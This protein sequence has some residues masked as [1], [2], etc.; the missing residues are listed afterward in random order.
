MNNSIM[1]I[2]A[3]ITILI[4]CAFAQEIRMKMNILYLT[5][6]Y[7]SISSI[8]T[9]GTDPNSHALAM[10][11][12][13]GMNYD[14]VA[15][16]TESLILEN[17]DVAL[18]N[19]IVIDGASQDLLAP[20]KSQIEDYQRKY[21]IRITY[22]NCEPDVT[23]FPE[24]NLNSIG[25][26]VRLTEQ[27]IEFAKKYQMNGEFVVF[28]VNN[29]TIDHSLLYHHYEV[30][31]ERSDVTPLLKY[32]YTDDFAGAIVNYNDL[33][34]IHFW[35]PFIDSSIASFVSHLWIS[36]ANY[37]MI[38]GYRRLYLGI[39]VDDFFS[40]NCFNKT[41]CVLDDGTPH[42]RTTVEDMENIA[43]WQKDISS[44]LPEGSDIKIELAINGYKILTK[45]QHKHSI[46]ENWDDSLYFDYTYKKP[47]EEHGSTRWG[48]DIDSNWDD[49]AL[50]KGDP[51]YK[52]FKD[53]KNQ[54]N[55]YWV[56]NTFSH[57]KLDFASYHD[58]DTEMKLNIKM[59]S[60]PYL[61]MYER[62]CFS[63]HSVISPKIS[64]LHN[65]DALKAFN[66]NGV[67]SAVGDTSRKDLSPA[68]F[69]LPLITNMTT[70]NFEGFTIIPR[71]TTEVYGDCSTIEE[72][73]A[74]YQLKHPD[75]VNVDWVTNL[76]VDA[77]RNV[78][79]FLKLRH[80]PYMF[81]ESNLRNADIAEVSREATNNM[82]LMQ[83]WV[84][85]LVEEINKYYYDLPIRSIKMD[86]LVN[87]YTERLQKKKCKPEF[88]MVMY[89]QSNIIKEITVEASDNCRVPLAIKRDSEFA[90]VQ[91]V[92]SEK[93]GNEPEIGWIDLKGSPVS[94]HFRKEIK[95]NDEDFVGKDVYKKRS[96]LSLSSLFSGYKIYLW[97]AG[98]ALFVSF[99][100]YLIFGR[101]K[102]YT[103]D[104]PSQSFS[105][106][107]S[108]PSLPDDTSYD[109]NNNNEYENQQKQLKQKDEEEE[110]ILDQRNSN[111][112]TNVSNINMNEYEVL[113]L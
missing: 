56:S 77:R 28:N 73:M 34:S 86:D 8:N 30:R 11:D 106:S 82:S 53:T 14:V 58:A 16:P 24:Y 25:R 91:N 50:Q 2:V 102:G 78:K 66:D 51:L 74:K 99:I 103:Y 72:N 4:S 109:N 110:K 76:N 69:Y 23:I 97:I 57:Q 22:L 60:E 27:G 21:N 3:I 92:E 75:D 35:I 37:G 33:E 105:H 7:N 47:L 107:P 32:D 49:D 55:F 48:I 90:D 85:R 59:S 20:L 84:E 83:D 19:T 112:K 29:Y 111:Y 89:Q 88:T 113:E 62:Q 101:R 40:D 41:N 38:D 96:T 54:D 18:Y 93:F 36:W 52:Y 64:G 42:Y 81:Y 43:K 87:T 63:K 79:N 61:G 13:Y 95:Y 1:F 44:R 94:V 15:L 70:S 6:S 9:Y 5:A 45:A 68:N 10:L 39:Q 98:F 12:A 31:I 104:Y 67:Y 71:H 46:I 80:D 65:A 17:N 26:D 108:L 100:I